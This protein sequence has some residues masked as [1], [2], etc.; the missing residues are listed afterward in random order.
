MEKEENRRNGQH[1]KVKREG[2]GRN[3]MEPGFVHVPVRMCC[4]CLHL[5]V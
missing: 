1:G 2:G 4:I 3:E 5:L